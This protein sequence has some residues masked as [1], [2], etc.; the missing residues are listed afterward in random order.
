MTP[1]VRDITALL[2]VTS[3]F[4]P[5]FFFLPNRLY[6][7]RKRRAGSWRGVNRWSSTNLRGASR[8]TPAWPS[9]SPLL[10]TYSEQEFESPL[11]SQGAGVLHGFFFFKDRVYC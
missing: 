10:I 9:Q 1:P 8:F 3:H 7:Q 5:I 6:M 11:V 4:S 2:H